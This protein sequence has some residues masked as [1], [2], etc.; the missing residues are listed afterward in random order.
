MQSNVEPEI[1][2][3]HENSPLLSEF[4]FLFKRPFFLTSL[5]ISDYVGFPL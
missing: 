4:R 5:Q 1:S 2:I 3:T